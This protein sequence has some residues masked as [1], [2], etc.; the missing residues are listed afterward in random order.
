MHGASLACATLINEIYAHRGVVRSTPADACDHPPAGM[1][2]L[3]AS[4]ILTFNIWEVRCSVDGALRRRALPY[5]VS[6]GGH[7]SRPA[8]R[9]ATQHLQQGY[10]AGATAPRC[11]WGSFRRVVHRAAFGVVSGSR[12]STRKSPTQQRPGRVQVT[13]V[14]CLRVRT[15]A[16]QTGP[17]S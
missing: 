11:P 8:R 16:G 7:W 14:S 9:R 2:A 12:P 15:A 6:G 17:P 13:P 1:L 10:C 4:M 3:V 5:G